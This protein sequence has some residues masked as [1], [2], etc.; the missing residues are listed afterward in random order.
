MTPC[1]PF[2]NIAERFLWPRWVTKAS[3]RLCR[4]TAGIF[5]APGQDEH[6]TSPR[7]LWMELPY[8]LLPPCP[9]FH[10]GQAVLVP[11]ELKEEG[12]RRRMLAQG[13][14]RGREEEDRQEE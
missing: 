10:W 5:H 12:E 13:K 8:L 4:A 6:F 14:A 9:L 2:I 3:E 1:Y 11:L 7:G